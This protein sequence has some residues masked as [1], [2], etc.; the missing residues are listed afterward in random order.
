MPKT[1]NEAPSDIIEIARSFSAKLNIGNYESR[2]FFCSRKE[3]CFRKDAAET[4]KRAF[5]FAKAEALRDMAEYK[6]KRDA[7]QKKHVEEVS[8]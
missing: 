5:Q 2:D 4:S 3:E 1:P 6:A 7:A 8:R